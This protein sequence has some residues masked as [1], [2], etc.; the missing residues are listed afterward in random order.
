MTKL[1]EIRINKNLSQSELAKL[2]GVNYRTLQDFDQGR[3]SL[4]NAKGEMIYR[5]SVALGCSSDE[6]LSAD[7][8]IEDN[9]HSHEYNQLQRLTAYA[10]KMHPED[11]HYYGKYYTFPELIKRPGL[12]MEHI[13]PTKQKIVSEIHDA[14]SSRV[15]LSSIMLFGSSI[16]MQCT[17]DSDTD[18][19]IRLNNTYNNLKTRD[20]ISEI[21]QEIC[22]WN[23]DIIWFD[24][25][26]PKDRIY[27]DI[28]KGVQIV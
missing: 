9:Q 24:R 26:S 1:Q 20:N 25:I 19:A 8:I 21:I 22:D 6:L 16:T 5:L 12:K 4:A 13:Y 10:D 23:A 27:H 15:E 17:Y 14:L 3:K 7:I 28:C 11:R 2:S 18:L